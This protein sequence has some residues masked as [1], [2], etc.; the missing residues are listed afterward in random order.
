MCLDATG[1]DSAGS[2]FETGVQ[3]EPFLTPTTLL[4]AE[5]VLVPQGSTLDPLLFCECSKVPRMERGSNSLCLVNIKMAK[6][7]P[8]C[9]GTGKRC[10]HIVC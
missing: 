10:I 1:S 3:C 6:K 9:G 5:K 8:L 4:K 2:L 7:K